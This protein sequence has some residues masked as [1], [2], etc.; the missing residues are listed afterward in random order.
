MA[1]AIKR[2]TVDRK[3]GQVKNKEIIDNNP[4]INEDEVYAPFSKI[5]YEKIM[6]QE[7]NN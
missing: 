5:I 1:L 6:S 2:V 4:D 7:G 3:T